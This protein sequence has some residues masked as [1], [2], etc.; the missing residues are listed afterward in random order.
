[1]TEF[2][3]FTAMLDSRKQKYELE[4]NNVDKEVWIETDGA[5]I[6]FVFDIEETFLYLELNSNVYC[7]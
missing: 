6:V 3:M 7:E 1:M 2:R 5:S 4:V